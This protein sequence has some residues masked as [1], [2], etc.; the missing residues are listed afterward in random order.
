MRNRRDHLH[1]QQGKRK[2][3]RVVRISRLRRQ[4]RRTDCDSRQR[5][6]PLQVTRSV[7]LGSEGGKGDDFV[8]FDQAHVFHD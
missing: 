7:A 2:A 1:V 4:N 8:P 6:G 5:N 3:V